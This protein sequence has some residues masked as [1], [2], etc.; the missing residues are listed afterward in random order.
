MT[1]TNSKRFATLIALIAAVAAFVGFAPAASAAGYGADIVINGNAATG[2]ATFS[3]NDIARYSNAD[4][5]AYAYVRVDGT[6]VSAVTPQGS[7]R[8]AADVE[9]NTDTPEFSDG[10]YYTADEAAEIAAA[11]AAVRTVADTSNAAYFYA[12]QVTKDANSITFIFKLT[13]KALSQG[14]ELKYDVFLSPVKIDNGGAKLTAAQLS[15]LR[16]SGLSGVLYSASANLP[17]TGEGGTEDTNAA[18]TTGKST[19][20]KTGTVMLP[21]IVAIAAIALVAAGVFAARRRIQR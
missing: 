9:T 2:T 8:A 16:A 20:S 21:Y 6:L 14:G 17:K 12:G 19:L 1:T 18:G 4:G 7:T 11:P 13:Q 5:V 10:A 3:A 15:Q